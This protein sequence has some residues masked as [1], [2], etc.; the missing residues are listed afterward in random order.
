M[1]LQV[2]T[3]QKEEFT[4]GT[5]NVIFFIER[6]KLSLDLEK[7]SYVEYTKISITHIPIPTYKDMLCGYVCD[8]P[9]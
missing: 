2:K 3:S 7:S 9:H 5:Q 8:P 1:S 6:D 4:Y